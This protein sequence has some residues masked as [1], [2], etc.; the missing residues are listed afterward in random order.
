[1]D[2][3][4]SDNHSFT[5]SFTE[6]NFPGWEVGEE[7]PNP[8]RH[9]NG[10]SYSFVGTGLLDEVEHRVGAMVDVRVTHYSAIR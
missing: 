10:D 7:V 1:M 5:L 9:P 3:I 8:Y 6:A 4:I 2:R